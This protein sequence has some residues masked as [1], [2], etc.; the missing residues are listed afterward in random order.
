MNVYEYVLKFIKFFSVL[1]GSF[2]N[3]KICVWSCSMP[4]NFFMKF[5]MKNKK[6]VQKGVIS[7]EK[8]VQK[9][10]TLHK[11]WVQ[12]GVKCVIM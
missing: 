5:S 2:K 7:N 6:W 3:N 1:K 4:W 12:K 10:V 8:W 9:G 11:K